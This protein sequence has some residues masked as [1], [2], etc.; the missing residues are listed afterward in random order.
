[1]IIVLEY[2]IKL[3]VGCIRTIHMYFLSRRMREGRGKGF[4]WMFILVDINL[5]F[6]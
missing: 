5:L 4:G 2:E 1:M 3:S 6:S